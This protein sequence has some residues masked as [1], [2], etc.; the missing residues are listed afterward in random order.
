MPLLYGCASSRMRIQTLRCCC[1]CRLKCY[2]SAWQPLRLCTAGAYYYSLP[3]YSS[4]RSGPLPPDQ[5]ERLLVTT[6]TIVVM[7]I[8]LPK[9]VGVVLNCMD[10]EAGAR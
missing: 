2:S 6:L 7:M 10:F 1:C 3:L 4:S 8:L 9:M 5:K